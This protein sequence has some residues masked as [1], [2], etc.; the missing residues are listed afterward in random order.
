MLQ[1]EH[2]PERTQGNCRRHQTGRTPYPAWEAQKTG[3]T[4]KTQDKTE[5]HP[6]QRQTRENRWRYARSRKVGSAGGWRFRSS[7]R[8]R[9]WQPVDPRTLWSSTKA[10]W[11]KRDDWQG[12]RS[13]DNRVLEGWQTDGRSEIHHALVFRKCF[14]RQDKHGL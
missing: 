1:E 6:F 8:M 5:S 12:E 9:H 3:Q 4:S 11:L 10:A 13:S 14:L 7:T 2:G